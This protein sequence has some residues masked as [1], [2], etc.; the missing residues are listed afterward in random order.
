MTRKYCLVLFA[1]PYPEI[2]LALLAE[3]GKPVVRTIRAW[4]G[5]W[6]DHGEPIHRGTRDVISCW[7]VHSSG[8]TY[9]A[10][11]ASVRLI[12]G[13]PRTYDEA[14]AIAAKCPAGNHVDHRSVD[15]FRRAVADAIA[16]QSTAERL[17]ADTHYRYTIGRIVDGAPVCR[18]VPADEM[19]S[20]DLTSEWQGASDLPDGVEFC[21]A[22]TPDGQ[23]VSIYRERVE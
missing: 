1:N 11:A 19:E 9:S 15:Y 14:V 2:G 13:T 12:D 8:G 18:D 17:S 5:K 20:L 23:P 6:D 22:Y 16:S 21:L 10:P 7:S 4:T 3:S